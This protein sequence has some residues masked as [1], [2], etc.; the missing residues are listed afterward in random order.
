MTRLPYFCIPGSPGSMAKRK[1][2]NLGWK[3]LL[4][5]IIAAVSVMGGFSLYE[6]WLERSA[7]FIHYPEFG[8]EIPVNY[9]IHGIDVSKYQD[10]IDWELVKEMKVQNVHIGFA[11]IKATEGLGNEDAYFGRNWKKAKEAGLIRGAYHF[12]LATKSGRMQAENFINSVTLK[13]GDLPPVLDIEQNYGV[14]PDKLRE[15]VKEW[16]ET[17]HNYY[18]VPPIIYTNVEFYKRFL[19]DDFDGYPLWV[20]H[21][22]QKER[23]RIYRAWSFWQHNESGRVNG[24]VTRVDFDVFNGDSLELSKILMN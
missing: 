21:Y 18:G 8:I 9:S 14:P 1:N 2:K 6:W 4:F 17:I 15:R 5:L 7:H 16:L 10:I 24:I 22:L 11:F 19:K 13:E 23:P 12:F 20:A 3:I